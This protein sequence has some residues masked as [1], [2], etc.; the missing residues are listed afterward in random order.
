VPSHTDCAPYTASRGKNAENGTAA[1]LVGKLS[2]M[3]W[4]GASR[5]VQQPAPTSLATNAAAAAALL[6]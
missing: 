2:G 4:I 1:Q 5:D 6:W 3:Q